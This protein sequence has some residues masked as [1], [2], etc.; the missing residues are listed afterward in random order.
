MGFRLLVLKQLKKTFI[1]YV[2]LNVL[3][4]PKHKYL[5]MYLTDFLGK[6]IKKKTFKI[7]IFRNVILF[8]Y[9]GCFTCVFTFWYIMI[10]KTFKRKFLVKV[11][12]IPM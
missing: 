4:F 12:F 5:C 7:H 6:I 10:L 2:S 11:A 1:I 9:K 3:S 8:L